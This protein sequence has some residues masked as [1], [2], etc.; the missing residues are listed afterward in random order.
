VIFKGRLSKTLLAAMVGALLAAGIGLCLHLF[1]IG[2]GLTYTSYDLL[3]VARGERSASEALIV[4]LDE[5][6]HDEL[7]QSL[8][9]A[10]DRSL[11]ARLIDRL[12]AAGAK[13]IVFD[14]VFS[15]PL[16]N[17]PG[18]DLHL[19]E[20]MKASGRV[21][22]AADRVPIGP[23]QNQTKPPFPLLRESAAD[24]GSAE[25]IPSPD[26]VIRE[27]TPEAE[28]YSLNWAAA[29]FVGAKATE[30]SPVGDGTHWLNYYGP[31][32]FLPWKS[33]QDALEPS[34][35][36]D[37]V[38]SNKVL[39]VGAHI[40]TKFAG[41][42]KDEYRSPFGLWSTR[43]MDKERGAMFVP[44]VE[45]QA[46]AFLNLLRGDWLV[47][48]PS[49]AERSMIVLLGLL[50]GFGL[51]QC[52]PLT[53]VGLALA[54]MAVVALA[55]YFLFVLGLT[56]FPWL[57]VETQIVIA[58]SWSIVFNSIQLY[59]QKRMY[60]HTLSLYLSPKLVKKFARDP[61]LLKPGAKEQTLTIL[62]T[63][64]ANFSELSQRIS[65]DELAKLMNNYFHTAVTKCIHKTDG[66]VVKYIGDA[67]FAFWNA[68][69]LQE[70][71]A[72][73]ACEAAL[74]FREHGVQ[75]VNGEPLRTRIGLHSG[76]AKVGNFGSSER[77]DYT[78]LGQAINLA[79]RLEGLNRFLGT[80]C[81]IS[82]DT[83]KEIG[84]RL[85]TRALGMFQLKGFDSPVQVHELVGWPAEEESTRPWREAF[86][87]ALHNYN[88][89]D[90]EFAGAGFRQT[91]ELR[92][93]DGPSKFYL[94]K[95]EE[96]AAENLP[97]DWATHT[98]LKEK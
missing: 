50:M 24:I 73:R 98:V 64:I 83:K 78:A 62:F 81:V 7:K 76:A 58:L 15:D 57:I 89:R 53:A 9:A 91:L 2:L 22:L 29:K 66:T 28:L 10:W 80:D 17:N 31:P 49:L 65:S 40:F 82:I 30:R 72:L 45:I 35:V 51:V 87:Q 96:L 8:S 74:L 39:F 52:R 12:T 11:H 47:R 32:K 60:E 75:H 54:G 4:Y 90:L 13:A 18:A 1:R 69:D 63:D 84:D 42:R 46:T 34:R 79:S 85:I 20:A 37:Q 3:L 44:G 6:S 14:I 59:V 27:H 38:F 43:E 68:P 55:A 26:L 94:A 88:N 5:K 97:E 33:Y 61:E 93:N 77:F 67:I 36:P 25:V 92:P 70:D 19:A 48:F 41:E 23:G 71:H 16:T 56:W 21:I 95:V 86:A